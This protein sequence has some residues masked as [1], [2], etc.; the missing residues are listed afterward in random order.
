VVDILGRIGLVGYGVVHL[1]VAWLALQV[2]IGV[3]GVSADAQGAVGTLARTRFGGLAL[4]ISAVGLVAFAVW[5]LS[6]AAVGFRWVCGRERARKRAGAI[7]KAIAM[8]G[9]AGVVGHYLLGRGEE[10]PNAGAVSLSADLLALPAGR[11][12]LGIAAAVILALAAGMVYT[13]LRCTFMGD[14]DVAHMSPMARR[15]IAVIGAIGHLARAVALAVIGSLIARAALVGDA[16]RAGGLDA[17]LRVLGETRLGFVLLV[18]VALGF[19]AYG[20]FCLADAFT[21]RA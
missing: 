20:I 11:A 5:Q 15:V 16:R 14:L 10:P 13:G 3:P 21:R 12:I 2:A 18:V 8:L 7:A 9:L 4:A 19:A 17:A 6:A 1:L